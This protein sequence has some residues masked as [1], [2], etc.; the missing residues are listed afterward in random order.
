MLPL[1]IIDLT[2]SSDRR[3]RL[4]ELLGR[5]KYVFF[6]GSD[7]KPDQKTVVDEEYRWLYTHFED[8]PDEEKIPFDLSD[9]TEEKVKEY[10]ERVY[11]FQNDLVRHGQ[12]YVQMVRHSS[13]RAYTTLNICVLGDASEAF[14]QLFFPSI[15]LFLQKEKGRMLANHIHQGMSVYG[16]LFV[17]SSINSNEVDN[18]ERLLRTLMEID[19]QYHISTVHGYDHML[20]FQD[21]QNRVDKYY[22]LLNSTEQAEYFYQCMVHLYYACNTQHPLISGVAAADSFYLSMGVASLMFDEGHQDREISCDISNKLLESYY[23]VPENDVVNAALSQASKKK[24]FLSSNAIELNRILQAYRP[25]L[26]TLEA[27][28]RDPHPDPVFDFSD[29]NLERRYYLDKGHLNTRLAE[30]RRLMNDEVETKTRGSLETI[31]K[32]FNRSLNNLQ[33]LQ[34]PESL[35]KFVERCNPSDGGLLHLE[36][37]LRDLKEKSA[38]NKKRAPDYVENII[39][40]NVF[41]IIPKSLSDDFHLYHYAYNQDIDSKDSRHAD[42]MKSEVVNDLCNHLKQETPVMSRIVRSLLLGLVAVLFMLPILH[43]LSPD[44]INIG[45]IKKTALIWAAVIFMIPAVIEAIMAIRYLIKRARKERKLRA[46]YLHDAYARIAN[47][48]MT[49]SGNFYDK[50]QKLCDMYISRSETIRKEIND[51]PI[52]GRDQSELPETLFNR[53]LLGGRFCNHEILSKDAQEPRMIYINHIPK[54]VNKLGPEDHFTLVHLFKEDFINLF[55]GIKIPESHPFVTNKSTGAVRLLS[56]EEVKE[57]RR[58]E[59]ETIR[60]RFKEHLPALIKEE[61]V[62]LA[63]PSASSMIYRNYDRTREHSFLKPFF[64]FAA[65]NGEFTTSADQE[66]VDIKTA[67]DKLREFENFVFPEDTVYQMEPGGEDDES[68]EAAA[69]YKKYIFLTRWVTFDSLALNRILP[70]EDFDLEEQKR[71]INE[72]ERSGKKKRSIFFSSEE[73]PEVKDVYPI[74]TSSVILWSLCDHDNSISWLKLFHALALAEARS[75]SEL[76]YQKLTTKD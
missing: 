30:F 60:D 2:Q 29:K 19:V 10:S 28:I 35:K 46:F 38:E 18:R 3:A 61:I 6:S 16:A 5:T 47:R 14:T 8:L 39:W 37:L 66:C 75:K 24:E 36:S 70:M 32:T 27:R 65:T 26:I 7:R 49:E 62:P 11:K 42:E 68:I 53:P 54:E 67:D 64:L 41:Q 25:E 1:W 43:F 45:N 23:A 17:P 73:K 15:A 76:I 52:P 59:W 58:Q 31:H 21:V 20:L 51:F 4:V 33:D 13:L 56:P 50:V 74:A 72:E 57:A 71:Q 44:F 69:L 9:A 22:H 40:E 12:K 34:F 55:D 48:I 63:S